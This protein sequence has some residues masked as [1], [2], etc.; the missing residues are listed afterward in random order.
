[1]DNPNLTMSDPQILAE[2]TKLAYGLPDANWLLCSGREVVDH[3]FHCSDDRAE[4]F[5]FRIDAMFTPLLESGRKM[6]PLVLCAEEMK[7]LVVPRGVLRFCVVTRGAARHLDLVSGRSLEFL[8]KY[9]RSLRADGAAVETI[10]EPVVVVQEDPEVLRKRE[11]EWRAYEAFLSTVLG[12]VIPRSQ[13]AYLVD[14]LKERVSPEEPVRREG[15]GEFAKALLEHVPHKG[16]R[17]AL[18]EE[19]LHHISE[20]FSTN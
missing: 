15:F 12:K 6:G 16:K 3:N 4:K 2:V 1:M 11:E 19:V 20:K 10:E 14:T 17:A 13:V 8:E 5:A 7:L 9:E 18:E